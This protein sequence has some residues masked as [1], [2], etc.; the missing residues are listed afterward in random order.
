MYGR[1]LTADESQAVFDLVREAEIAEANQAEVGGVV[2]AV[3]VDSLIRRYLRQR[4]ANTSTAHDTAGAFAMFA[5]LLGEG[6]GF[7]G[8][9]F[10]SSTVGPAGS[11]GIL[12]GPGGGA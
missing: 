8:G 11:A 1:R 3:D 6:M 5:Q 10:G 12:A 2:E 9:G 7:G 4:D